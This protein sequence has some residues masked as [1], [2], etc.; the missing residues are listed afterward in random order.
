[1]NP[2]QDHPRVRSTKVLPLRP[3]EPALALFAALCL[4]VATTVS[5]TT[6]GYE[7]LFY[8]AVMVIVM[9]VVVHV[10]RR[11]GLSI[12]SLW[13]LNIWGAAHMAGGML[14]LP[15][16]TG[17]LYNLWLI[18]HR[19]GHGLKYDQLI[20]AYGFGV[21][22]WVCWQGLRP[23]LAVPTPTVGVV[24]LCAL[25]AMG[26]GALNEVIEFTAT[27][28]V[29][30]TNVGDYDNNMWDLTFNMFGAVIV[31][32]IIWTCGRRSRATGPPVLHTRDHGGADRAVSS[33][34]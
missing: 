15:A 21:T 17:V 30:K 33:S 23:R 6:G 19:D 25:S 32:A 34:A 10:H 12:A 7:F 29:E 2:V 14:P 16:P 28:L 13:A 11:V 27:K 18:G 22:A 26:L 31:A 20:H 5:L 1:M 3:G 24:G 4:G 9:G 8:I